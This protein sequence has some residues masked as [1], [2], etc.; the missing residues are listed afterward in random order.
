[1]KLHFYLIVSFLALITNMANASNWQ[2]LGT[3]DSGEKAIEVDLD[4]ISNSNGLRK[5]W[6][7]T[8][9]KKP[10]RSAKSAG[11]SF[12]ST[13]MLYYFDCQ[14]KAAGVSQK[15]DYELPN[16]GGRVIYTVSQPV[17]SLELTDIAPDSVAEGISRWAC[18][19]DQQK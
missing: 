3:T 19:T 13:R 1:M 5:V 14:A 15:I 17:N 16:G 11:E 6:T 4:S 7:S 18:L 9:Y 8:E 2:L 12:R 10:Q